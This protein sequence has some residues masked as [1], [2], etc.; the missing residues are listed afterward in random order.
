MKTGFINGTFDILHPG[1][2]AMLEFAKSQCDEL[3]VALDT[4]E[5]VR[6]LKGSDRPIN[7]AV[8][9]SK[10]MLAIRWVDHVLFFD[11]DESLESCVKSIAPDIMVVGSDYRNKNVIGSQ[12]AK[13]LIFFER[14]P[15]YSSTSIIESILDRRRVHG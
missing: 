1:H 15:R 13:K 4:D 5:R 10:M 8:T 3:F 7:D 9:R 6:T 12:Y 2:L 14:D 11:S